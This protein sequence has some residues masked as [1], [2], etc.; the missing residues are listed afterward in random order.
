MYSIAA[1][2]QEMV[3]CNS[4]LYFA[5]IMQ[6][7][8]MYIVQSLLI[9]QSNEFSNWELVVFFGGGGGGGGEDD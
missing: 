8:R 3:T 5:C 4:G 7:P 6:E 1:A 2:M 9:I